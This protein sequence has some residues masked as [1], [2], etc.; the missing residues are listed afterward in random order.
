[1]LTT[2]QD[3]ALVYERNQWGLRLGPLLRLW[4]SLAPS[5]PNFAQSTLPSTGTVSPLEAFLASEA[6]F[7][8]QLVATISTGLSSLSDLVYGSGVLTPQVQVGAIST[9]MT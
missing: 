5:M 4:E 3:S 7:A 8:Q 9:V 6:A 1:M 2:L